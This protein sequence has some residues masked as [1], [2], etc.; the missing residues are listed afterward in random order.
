M[1]SN[2]AVQVSENLLSVYSAS[3]A[4]F[5]E[6]EEDQP[7]AGTMQ[8][9]DAIFEELWRAHGKNIL[10]TTYRITRNHEDAEDALQDSFLKAFVHLQDFDGRASLS[11]WLTRIAINSALA[12]LRKRA[13]ASGLSIDDLGDRGGNRGLANLPD[14]APSPEANCARREQEEILRDGIRALQSTSRN[15]VQLQQIQEHSV[16]ETAQMI[17]ISVSAAKSRIHRAKAA[18]RASLKPK[19]IR[20]LRR[21][22]R[23]QWLP[24][25]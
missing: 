23:L 18:L 9:Q 24:V 17:G 1:A 21:T 2:H 5:H 19:P 22:D 10:R 14:R 3:E 4:S 7:A 8:G 11:T 25:A 15:A 20:R 6:L 16:T 12:I 13:S